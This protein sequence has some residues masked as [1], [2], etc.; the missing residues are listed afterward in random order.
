MTPEQAEEFVGFARSGDTDVPVGAEDFVEALRDGG[1]LSS[2]VVPHGLWVSH[3]DEPVEYEPE[4][5]P[6]LLEDGSARVWPGRNPA[7]ED[8]WGSFR[9][10]VAADIVAAWDRPD[11]VIAGSDCGFDTFAGFGAVDP[12]IAWAKLAALAEGAARVG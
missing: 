5:I 11:R 8:R 3:H 7:F 1:D 12:E 4:A 2:L 6:G 9:E 10:V